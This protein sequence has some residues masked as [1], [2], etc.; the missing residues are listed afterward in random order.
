MV[1]IVIPSQCFPNLPM[2]V[3]IDKQNK[4]ELRHVCIILGVLE[5]WRFYIKSKAFWFQKKKKQKRKK[6]SCWLIIWS[7]VTEET[8]KWAMM[9][10]WKCHLFLHLR[11]LENGS[12]RLGKIISWETKVNE[13]CDSKYCF[14]LK[15][16][17]LW[18]LW[19][20]PLETELPKFKS[21]L[22]HL[23]ILWPDKLL[24]TSLICKMNITINIVL[25]YWRTKLKKSLHQCQAQ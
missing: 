21:W 12:K 18:W 11:E 3:S 9:S 17:I 23:R 1:R 25:C 6:E 8:V 14:I 13:F 24:I 22:Y 10:L 19:N 5:S 7:L 16:S 2:K 20:Q 4:F 15:D